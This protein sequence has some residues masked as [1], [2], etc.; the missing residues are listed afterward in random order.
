MGGTLDEEP[1][2]SD[3]RDVRAED[4]CTDFRRKTHFELQAASAIIDVDSALV[5]GGQARTRVE[6]MFR[7]NARSQNGRRAY[8]E[9]VGHPF[10]ATNWDSALTR[11]HNIAIALPPGVGEKIQKKAWRQVE[12]ALQQGKRG[13]AVQPELVPQCSNSSLN[14]NNL[15]SSLTRKFASSFLLRNKKGSNMLPPVNGRTSH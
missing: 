15:D 7:H 3:V 12:K 2:I 5:P 1:L 14:V 13:F 9:C 4:V 8:S 11:K 10:F 6:A